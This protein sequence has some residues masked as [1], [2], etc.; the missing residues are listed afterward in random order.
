MKWLDLH[1]LLCTLLSGC[2]AEGSE[3]FCKLNALQLVPSGFHVFMLS[4]GRLKIA[5]LIR[6]G[7]RGPPNPP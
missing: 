2:S 5:V 1:G 7:F 4:Y 3:L 6:G